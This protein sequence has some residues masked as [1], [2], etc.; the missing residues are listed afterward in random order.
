MIPVI[1]LT[2]LRQNCILKY[3]LS[4]PR[5]FLSYTDSLWYDGPDIK[6]SLQYISET[7]KLNWKPDFWDLKCT[8]QSNIIKMLERF[9]FFSKKVKKQNVKTQ[10]KQEKKKKPRPYS[11]KLLSIQA[12]ILKQKTQAHIF[13]GDA[14]Q[15]LIHI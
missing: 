2:F 6:N 4:N 12:K 8:F 9:G 3:G 10:L 5:C 7:G 1:E 11:G 15:I 14:K 13:V